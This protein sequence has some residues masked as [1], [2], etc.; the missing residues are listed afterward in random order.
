MNK[1][2]RKEWEELVLDAIDAINATATIGLDKESLSL[3]IAA[4]TH[5]FKLEREIHQLKSGRRIAA[6]LKPTKES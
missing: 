6:I 5:I 1:A 3:I 4:N 2:Q